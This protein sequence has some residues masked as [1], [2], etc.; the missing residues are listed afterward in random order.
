VALVGNEDIYQCKLYRI[1]QKADQL[2]AAG[3]EVQIYSSSKQIS[4]FKAKMHQFQAVIF[5]RVPAFPDVIEAITAAANYGLATFYEIDDIVFD[6][7]HFPPSFESY[8]NQITREH[9]DAMACGVPLFEHAMS[10]CDYG[11]ASTATIRALMSQKVRTGQAF[12]HHNALGNLHMLASDMAAIQS[13]VRPENAPVVIFY[14]SGTKAHKQEFHDILEPALAEM[15]RRFPQKIEIRLV[16]SFDAL[17]HLDVE[18]DPVT[19]INPVWDFEDYCE[20]LAQA[21]INLSILSPSVLTDAKSEIKWMEAAMF[22]IPSVVSATA[23]HRETIIDGETGILCETRADFEKALDA[24]ISSQELRH[25]IGAAAKEAVN[26][27]YSI[28]VLG[29][30]LTQIFNHVRPEIAAKT[31]LLIVNVFYPPQAIGGATRVVHDNVTILKSIYGDRFEIDVVCTLEG[32]QIPYEISVYTDKGVRVWAISTPHDP[33]IDTKARDPRMGE[34]FASILDQIRPDLIHFHCIQ[35]LTAEIVETARMKRVPY[36]ITMHDAW[37][38]SPNQFVLDHN[39]KSDFYD[40]TSRDLDSLPER[41][42][43][44]RKP[45][46]GSV[47]LLP[48]SEAFAELHRKVGLERVMVVENGVSHLPVATRSPSQSGRVRLAHIGGA[49]AHKGYHHVRNALMSKSYL[50]RLVWLSTKPGEQHPLPL[51]EKF[52]SPPWQI[53]MLR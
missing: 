9:Y 34:I 24:L 40:Y 48:V 10:L 12:E 27:D 49:S 28:S 47:W 32:G 38:I 41:A 21:D 20:M 1:D 5:F 53:F 46:L 22:G 42:R 44:L 7:E 17:K 26:R 30:N 13:P 52:P 51:R 18:K 23:T 45:L 50:C 4:E 11:I 37:W 15:L 8:A 33:D 25:R 36:V 3:F 19:L 14:G 43:A 2:R 29:Q 6:T 16:G 31:R 39:G 35:R